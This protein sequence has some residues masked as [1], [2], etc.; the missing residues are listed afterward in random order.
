MDPVDAATF[1]TPIMAELFL[2]QGKPQRAIG[3]LRHVVKERP[4]DHK[5]FARLA[6]LEAAQAPQGS[7]A[8]IFREKMRSMVEAI[9]G[10]TACAL[11]GFDGIAI[12][13]YEVGGC[14]LDIPVLLNEYATAAHGLRQTDQEQPLAGAMQ[15][16]VIST[17]NLTA[18]IRLLNH[19]YF[20][21]VVLSPEGLSGKAR[22]LMRQAAPLFIEELG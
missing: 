2:A 22:F 4:H 19:D 14:A 21:A 8:M 15:E 11:M 6:E 18:V 13:C 5:A 10:A 20:L 16:M 9:P 3:V 1:N 7:G 17:A 12:D